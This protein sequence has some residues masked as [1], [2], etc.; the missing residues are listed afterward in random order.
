MFEIDYFTTSNKPRFYIN[1]QPSDY[2]EEM[3]NRF[4]YFCHTCNE[5][6]DHCSQ[7]NF[8]KRCEYRSAHSNE[9]YCGSCRSELVYLT[10]TDSESD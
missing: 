8:C 4:S 6:R 3:I 2:Y 5:A 7:C 9:L 10:D 1:A